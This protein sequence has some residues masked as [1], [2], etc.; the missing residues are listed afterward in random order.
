MCISYFLWLKTKQKKQVFL[1]F[2]SQREELDRAKN[3]KK[4]KRN[5]DER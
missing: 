1:S 5:D 3:L 4:R 2:Y